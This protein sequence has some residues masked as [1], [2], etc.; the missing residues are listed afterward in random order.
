M[1]FLGIGDCCDLAAL[2]LRLVAE[3][4]EV[5]VAIADPLC[6]GTLAPEAGID[7]YVGRLRDGSDV[8]VFLNRF[9]AAKPLTASL[10]LMEYT[11]GVEMGVGAYF[12]G[13]RF[14]TPACLDWARP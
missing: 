13:E 2:Y 3:G 14:L 12:D 10:M 5:R 9:A 4:H 6:H 1:R 7:N 8:R 11:E